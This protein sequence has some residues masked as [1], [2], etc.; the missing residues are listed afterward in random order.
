MCIV[1]IGDV[2]FNF[3]YSIYKLFGILT[4]RVM[5]GNN[6]A[7]TVWSKINIR[8]DYWHTRLTVN[9]AVKAFLKKGDS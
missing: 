5:G 8:V 6:A 2:L 9:G 3:G 1:F 7:H 4:V